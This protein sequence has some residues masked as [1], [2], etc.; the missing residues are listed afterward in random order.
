MLI[1]LTIHHGTEKTQ[2]IADTQHFIIFGSCKSSNNF[3]CIH[4]VH[5]SQS[6][7]TSHRQSLKKKAAAR[8]YQ[9]HILD[10]TSTHILGSKRQHIDTYTPLETAVLIKKKTN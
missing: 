6:N 10:N 2:P 9:I 1:S 3:F 4:L 5:T 7:N 8:A